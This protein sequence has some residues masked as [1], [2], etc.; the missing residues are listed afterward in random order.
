M[1]ANPI[2]R[3]V[4]DSVSSISK[5]GFYY[6][7]ASLD[8]YCE[9]NGGF[10]LFSRCVHISLITFTLYPQATDYCENVKGYSLLTSISYEEWNRL[11]E[12]LRL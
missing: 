1:T 7:L 9:S 2:K 8:A 6:F 12:L 5:Y 3:H 4:W 11:I 10:R